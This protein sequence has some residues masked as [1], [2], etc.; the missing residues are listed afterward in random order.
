M[1]DCLQGV[2]GWALD[3]AALDEPPRLELLVGEKVV[4]S[5]FPTL[6]R[7][8]ISEALGTEVT[9]G[10][11]FDPADLAKLA[12]AASSDQDVISVR[13]AGT[14]LELGIGDEAPRAG[15]IITRLR[16][17]AE[18]ARPRRRTADL[19]L[20]L[21]D[22]RVE[23]ADM[24]QLPLRPLPENHQGFVETVSVDAS[25]QVWMIGWMQR[26]HLTEFAAVISERR[27][28]PAAVALMTYERE[29]LPA[30]ACGVIGL[31]SSEWRPSS[32]HSEFHVFFGNGGRFH[33]LA[34]VPVRLITSAELT[35]E[36]AGV[37]DRILG[38][39]RAIAL[40]RMLTSLES[41]MPGFSDAQAAG[42]ETSVDSVLLVPGLGCLIE[43]WLI[44]PLKRVEGLRLRLGGAVMSA[45]PE[46]ICWKPRPDLLS[47]FPGSERL[48]QRAGFVA[49]FAGGTDVDDVTDPLLKIVFQD[50]ASANFPLLPRV[51]RRLGHSA[52]VEDAL[53]FYPALEEEG[54][55]PGFAKAAIRACQAGMNPPVIVRAA[56]FRQAILLV[57]PAD[58]CD[59]FLL[60]SDLAHQVRT[61]LQGQDLGVVLVASS[62]ANRAD[63]TWMFRE[64]QRDAGIPSSLIVIDEPAQ[65]IAQLPD[66]L[67]D[68]GAA[69]FVF[70]GPGVFLTGAGWRQAGEF[71]RGGS[72]DLHFFGLETDDFDHQE[73]AHG[74]TARCFAWNTADF[75]RWAVNAPSFLGGFY[76]EN[77]LLRQ[78]VPHTVHPDTAR[79]SRW[80][81]PTRIQAAVN[82]AV[83]DMKVT[84]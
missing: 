66:L 74:A 52:S 79:N 10:F 12:D 26:G 32:A 37:R 28:I 21:D 17:L 50:G 59:L 45:Q 7:H 9:A 16:A 14:A 81:V 38:E 20:L 76:R 3:L 64:F 72:G 57:L 78:A 1:V 42:T 33:L 18:P 70:V 75:L 2:R 6:P 84:R 68:V 56:R 82:A 55:F 4:A 44:S 83:Y 80:A 13:I 39:G 25:G 43:G 58:R 73:G 27:K 29:D 34:H 62:T 69:R 61:C 48:V 30:T 23:A 15:D 36:Y 65:A 22:L 8:D 63:A 31:L 46:T 71:M 47:A 24:A 40:Q 5:A 35:A 41:W 77:G 51:F 49:L 53:R 54:F 11:L 67:Q 60:F 19:E